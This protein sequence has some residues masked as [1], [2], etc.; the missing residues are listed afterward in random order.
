MLSLPVL[1]MGSID[2]QV[3]RSVIG[4]VMVPMMHNLSR[5]ELSTQSLLHHHPML[6]GVAV[7]PGKVMVVTDSDHH[8]ASC[9]VNI[10]PTLPRRIL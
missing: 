6:R 8:I 5:S 2:L 7:R 10:A 9:R 1:G 3:L 4:R